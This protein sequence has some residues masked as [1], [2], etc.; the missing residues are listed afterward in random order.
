MASVPVASIWWIGLKRPPNR[1]VCGPLRS[2]GMPSANTLPVW[3]SFAA[4]AMSSGVTRLRVP[5]WSSL[6]QRPQFE[7]FLDASSIAALPTL[8]SIGR[9]PPCGPVLPRNSGRDIGPPPRA[10][11]RRSVP[12]QNA[13][14]G[15]D[16]RALDLAEC[17]Q[18]PVRR[19]RNIRD[20]RGVEGPQRVV[21]GVDDASWRAGGSGLAGPLGAELRIRRGRH[22]VADLDVGHL[23]RHGNEV[24]GHVAVEELTACVIDAMLEQRRTDAL[25]HAAAD[26]LV[27][28]LRVDHGAA[29]LDAPVLQQPD[30]AGV[31]VD[32]QVAR[33]DAVGEG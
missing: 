23:A 5:I 14:A 12:A 29:V 21:D 7:S 24:V 27:D 33:L 26:L 2:S 16:A 19:E 9:F 20:D 6:P 22:H 17:M 15:R 13:R 18:H 25:H 31:G 3:M 30:E 1:P 11:L 28:Q 4:W 32:L 10:R 8:I